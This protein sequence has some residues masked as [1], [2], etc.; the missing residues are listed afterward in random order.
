MTTW[1]TTARPWVAGAV[2]LMLAVASH[3]PLIAQSDPRPVKPTYDDGN[4]EV[5]PVRGGVYLVA[6]SGANISVQLDADG[7]LLVDTSVAAMSDKVLAAIRT[8]P[9]SR[10][11]RSSIPA[12]THITPAATRRFRPPGATS[13]RGSAGKTDGNRRVSRGRRSSRTNRCS[14]A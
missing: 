7:V 12:R 2:A 14:T 13:M 9:A 6:G 4:V 3:G 5:V 8:I 11:G 1:T 10:S